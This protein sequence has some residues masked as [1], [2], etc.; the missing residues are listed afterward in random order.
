MAHV[1][2]ATE[3]FR[4]RK[5]DEIPQAL[6]PILKASPEFRTSWHRW[7]LDRLVTALNHGEYQG[8]DETTQITEVVEKFKNEYDMRAPVD[9]ENT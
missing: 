9:D 1:H 6:E 8:S 4:A 5:I 3:R 7:W 2:L